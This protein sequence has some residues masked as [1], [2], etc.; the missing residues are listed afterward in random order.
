MIGIA[1]GTFLFR[2]QLETVVEQ[3]GLPGFLPR[4]PVS[5]TK[6]E[7]LRG[8]WVADVSH[9]SPFAHYFH[10]AF[11]CLKQEGNQSI[12]QRGHGKP[13]WIFY[14]MNRGRGSLIPLNLWLSLDPDWWWIAESSTQAMTFQQRF[15]DA[16]WR[17]VTEMTTNRRDERDMS[18][19]ECQAWIQSGLALTPF[20]DIPWMPPLISEWTWRVLFP[21]PKTTLGLFLLAAA[22]V[23]PGRSREKEKK[24]QFFFGPLLRASRQCS[25]CNLSG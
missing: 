3:H 20:V 24:L 6:Q 12:S 14:L 23:S 10:L 1:V 19:K 9:V 15:V 17:L 11:S 4:P 2:W 21:P 13:T 16:H 22:W 7:L 8:T 18:A 5:F 25:L